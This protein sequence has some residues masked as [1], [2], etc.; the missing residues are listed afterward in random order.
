MKKSQKCVQTLNS[1][2]RPVQS[3]LNNNILIFF[4][5]TIRNDQQNRF[6]F[7]VPKTAGWARKGHVMISTASNGPV[8]VEVTIPGTNFEIRETVTNSLYVEVALPDS[9][10]FEDT[11]KQERK[12]VIVRASVQKSVYVMVNDPASGAGGDGFLVL[13]I[14]QLGT[15]HYVLAY[16]PYNSG[17]PSFI[18]VSAV[19]SKAT[20]VEIRTNTKQTH[21][22]VLRQYESYRLNGR[23]GSWED[24]S[25]SRVASDHPI[26]VISGT[27]GSIIDHRLDPVIESIPPVSIWGTHVVLSPFVGRQSGYTY[28]ILGTNITTEVTISRFGTVVLKEGQWYEGNVTD[29]TIVTIDSNYPILA[30]QYIK[31]EYRS[32]IA[33]HTSMILAPSTNMYTTNSTTFPV[34]TVAGR[35]Y[36][37][38][39]HV[40]IECMKVPGLLYDENT[41]MENWERLTSDNGGMCSVRG[42]VTAGSVHTISHGD[43]EVKFTVAVYGLGEDYSASYAYPA[44]IHAIPDDY[45]KPSFI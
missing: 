10:L 31:S 29:N 3:C 9:V 25:G 39:I 35:T 43:S 42:D 22:I 4:S 23:L 32:T 26:T 1:S 40:I 27:E 28:R 6:V 7:A 44:A 8:N 30:M 37:Y 17:Y 20:T 21:R 14:S 19:S 2:K 34:F 16:T 41:S 33:A 12:T 24:L 36:K 15:D 5:E 11:G 18:C 13:P 45:G 38:S